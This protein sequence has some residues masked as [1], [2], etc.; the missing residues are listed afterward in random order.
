MPLGDMPF[1]SLHPSFGKLNSKLL[2]FASGDM[3]HLSPVT[4]GLCFRRSKSQITTFKVPFT[5]WQCTQPPVQA[6]EPTRMRLVF[7]FEKFHPCIPKGH[8]VTQ[9]GK[10]YSLLKDSEYRMRFIMFILRIRLVGKMGTRLASTRL[11]L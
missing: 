9:R 7:V 3:C 4:A 8:V 10:E 6:M 11:S 2:D 5:P 1:A